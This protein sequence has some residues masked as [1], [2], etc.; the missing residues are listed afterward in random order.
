MP[1]YYRIFFHDRRREQKVTKQVHSFQSISVN[2]LV[3]IVKAHIHLVGIDV[4]KITNLWCL[5]NPWCMNL[6]MCWSNGQGI[7]VATGRMEMQCIELKEVKQPTYSPIRRRCRTHLI[8]WRAGMI[9]IFSWGLRLSLS[10]KAAASVDTARR[11]LEQ[12]SLLAGDPGSAFRTDRWNFSLS[13]AGIC[14]KNFE[15][16]WACCKPRFD[17]GAS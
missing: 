2:G 17:N 1:P 10:R 9:K 14:W 13:L 3:A 4:L 16:S 12:T 7:R 6:S 5:V 8:S 11:R 15:S